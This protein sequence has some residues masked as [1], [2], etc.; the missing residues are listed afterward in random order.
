MHLEWKM[1]EHW[2]AFTCWFGRHPSKQML[3]VTFA[4]G[5]LIDFVELL[6]DLPVS[7]SFFSSLY[8]NEG[9]EFIILRII[10]GVGLG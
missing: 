4:S 1:C 3:Q 7:S 5:C 8:W 10:S 9:I 6:E 2:S